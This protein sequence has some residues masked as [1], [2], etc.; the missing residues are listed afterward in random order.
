M[1]KVDDEH[2]FEPKAGLVVQ[3]NGTMQMKAGAKIFKKFK[4]FNNGPDPLNIEV[5]SSIAS[6]VKIRTPALT[7]APGGFEYI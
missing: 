7:I 4:F 6:I 5:K 3:D 1:L 2:E